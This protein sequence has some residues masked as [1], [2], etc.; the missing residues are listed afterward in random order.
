MA[1]SKLFSRT[2]EQRNGSLPQLRALIFDLNA[3]APVEINYSKIS[4][5]I[6]K[7][8]GATQPNIFE[9][10]ST[11]EA[12]LSEEKRSEFS[13]IIYGLLDEVETTQ[14]ELFRLHQGVKKGLDSIKT[15]KLT[16]ALTTSVGGAATESFLLK[17]ELR[18]AFA[19]VFSRDNRRIK[20]TFDLEKR[21]NSILE[22]LSFKPDQCIYFCTGLADLQTAKTLKIR[23][24]VLPGGRDRIDVLVRNKPDGM[25]LTLEELPGLLSIEASRS[26]PAP[27][28]DLEIESDVESSRMAVGEKT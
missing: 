24:I 7:N 5:F 16:M 4:E 3:L 27:K 15:A 11:L 21:L 6:R 19:E 26:P 22:K 1:E 9:Q 25:L 12:T 18:E 10:I 14:I 2:V 23:T 28:P 8:F 13:E 20:E 17:N